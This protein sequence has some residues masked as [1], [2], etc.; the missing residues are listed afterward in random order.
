[1]L[2]AVAAPRDVSRRFSFILEEFCELRV[3]DCIDFPQPRWLYTGC[4][5][6]SSHLCVSFCLLVL[7]IHYLGPI[8]R[9]PGLS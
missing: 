6:C 9:S 5:L 4:R 3:R 2:S 1:M 7:L 8:A